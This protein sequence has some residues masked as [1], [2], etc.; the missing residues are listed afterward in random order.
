MKVAILQYNA[1]NIRSVFFAL[2]RLGVEPIITNDIEELNKADRII[3][4]GVGEASSAIENLRENKL[5]NAIV[6]FKQPVLGIC[7]GMQLLCKYSEEGNTDGLAVFNNNVKRF[8]KEKGYKIPHIGWNT[9]SKLNSEL[10]E[11]L[12]EN[13]YVYFVHSYYADVNENTNAVCNYIIEYSAGLQKN[14][15]YATQFHPEKSGD[16]GEKIL[17]NFLNI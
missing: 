8:P 9:I 10:Y 16:I 13:D 7:L 2:K 6:N 11:N 12:K 14:N 1:G 17:Q 5:D 4:P 15:F 3:F